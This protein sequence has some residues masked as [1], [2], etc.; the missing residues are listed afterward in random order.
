MPTNENST[1]TCLLTGSNTEN[2]PFMSDTAA[3]S[4]SLIII[5]APGRGKSSVSVTTPCSKIPCGL[6]LLWL[7]VMRDMGTAL[8]TESVASLGVAVATHGSSMAMAHNP[9]LCI[10]FIAV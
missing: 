7:T 5:C 6:V 8:F 9:I 2:S 3:I 4:S 10:L 1:V